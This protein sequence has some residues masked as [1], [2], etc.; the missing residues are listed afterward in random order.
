MQIRDRGEQQS[1]ADR[2]EQEVPVRIEARAERDRDDVR[3][4]RDRGP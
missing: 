3:D 4:A 2:D 1:I